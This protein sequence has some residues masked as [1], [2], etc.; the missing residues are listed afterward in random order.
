MNLLKDRGKKPSFLW[1]F[2]FYC[3]LKIVPMAMIAFEAAIKRRELL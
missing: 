2:V 1:N 3:I